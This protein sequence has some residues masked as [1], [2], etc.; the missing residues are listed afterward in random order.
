MTE[1]KIEERK[2]LMKIGELSMDHRKRRRVSIDLS[3]GGRTDQ[4]SR[5]E[6]D[7]NVLMRRYG[8][9]G[10]MP[11]AGNMMYG[12]FSSVTDYMDAKIMVQQAE[13]DFA[14][15]PS[16]IRARFGNSPE[17]MLDFVANASRQELEEI[18]MIAP[19]PGTAPDLDESDPGSVEEPPAPVE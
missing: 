5:D 18:G 12:N 19:E 16:E 11:Q 9:A 2:E 10:S 13:R 14:E 7:I 6:C 4:S 1:V 8:R 3:Q 17:A 15:V